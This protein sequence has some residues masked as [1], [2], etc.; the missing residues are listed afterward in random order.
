MYFSGNNLCIPFP[1]IWSINN[2]NFDYDHHSNVKL[3][4]IIEFKNLSI[5][6]FRGFVHYI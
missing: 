6:R 1:D 5:H 2:R 3:I 4:I